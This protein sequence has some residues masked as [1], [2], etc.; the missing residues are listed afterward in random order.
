[1][2]GAH[3]QLIKRPLHSHDRTTQDIVFVDLCRRTFGHGPRHS[4]ALDDL[5]QAIALALR[6]L[7]G[8]VEQLIREIGRQHHSCRKHRTGQTATTSLVAAGFHDVRRMK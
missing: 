7:L 1:M 6:E 4:L 2:A 3:G 8:I 5:A